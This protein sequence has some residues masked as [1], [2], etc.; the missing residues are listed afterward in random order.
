MISNCHTQ[1]ATLKCKRSNIVQ[2]FD[3]IV[4][5]KNWQRLSICTYHQSM[6]RMERS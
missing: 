2:L 6:A 4:T 5:G 1:R 3:V